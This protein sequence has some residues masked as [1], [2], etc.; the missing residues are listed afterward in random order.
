MEWKPF[1]QHLPMMCHE[2]ILLQR[3]ITE[4]RKILLCREGLGRF[5]LRSIKTPPT[6]PCTGE[7]IRSCNLGIHSVEAVPIVAVSENN[8]ALD[9]RDIP[10]TDNSRHSDYPGYSVDT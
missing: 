8:M 4:Q 7:D 6:S 3:L 2:E 9:T 10:D 5:L 1:A